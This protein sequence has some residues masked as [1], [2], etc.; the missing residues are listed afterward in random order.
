MKRA[1]LALLGTLA[2]ACSAQPRMAE[3]ELAEVG[4][5]DVPAGLKAE[6]YLGYDSER[7][8]RLSFAFTATRWLTW[9]GGPVRYRQLLLVSVM[10]ADAPDAEYATRPQ[11]MTVSYEKIVQGAARP[12]GSGRLLMTEG[13]YHLDGEYRPAV[14]Y[15]YVD[16]ARR[17]Q[18][19]W[20][21]VRTELDDATATAVLS[22]MASSFRLTQDPV[23]VMAQAR[24]E[25]ARLAQVQADGDSGSHAGQATRLRT[26]LPIVRN[27]SFVTLAV[28]AAVNAV[29]AFYYYA[30][31]AKAVWFDD[32]PEDAEE[33]DERRGEPDLGRRDEVRHVALERALGEVGRELEQGHERGDVGVRA[34]VGLHIG[35]AALEERLRPLAG[36]ILDSVVELAA[37]VVALARVALGVLVGQLGT[38][39]LH[40]KGAGVIFRRNQ[41]NMFFLA[42]AFLG[43]GP[44]YFRIKVFDS[45]R[46][47]EHGYSA[48]ERRIVG[49]QKTAIVPVYRGRW[50]L[51]CV[52]RVSTKD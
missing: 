46:W 38:L 16:K 19:A 28:I 20:H 37:A 36:E 29:I 1:A 41:L 9:P 5:I 17:L 34:A 44:G 40:D 15:V 48:W 39:R 14:E 52:Y 3:R 31:I 51:E 10:A 6:R 8:N 18:I 49:R 47:V 13:L 25:P 26:V 22:R 23:A 43:Q 2:L 33:A 11:G 24:A 50:H 12:L 21:A 35:E 4:R 30:R 32:V 45:R 7:M 42:L 27:V